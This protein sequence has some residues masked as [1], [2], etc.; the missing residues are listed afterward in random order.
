M[1]LA[2]YLCFYVNVGAGVEKRQ[3]LIHH[4][5]PGKPSNGDNRSQVKE[6]SA[7]RTEVRG[8][9]GRWCMFSF[10]CFF[11][12]NTNSKLSPCINRGDGLSSF[13]RLYL[14]LTHI[15]NYFSRQSRRI[16]ETKAVGIKIEFPSP[17]TFY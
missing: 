2:I 11:P 13:N 5:L 14:V 3:T 12:S 7:T 15:V 6:R 9:A 8:K 4:P 17:I 16:G 1:Q 10:C